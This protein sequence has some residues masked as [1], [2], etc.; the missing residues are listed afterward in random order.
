MAIVVAPVPTVVP[1]T[2]KG[3]E[4]VFARY[5]ILPGVVF[6]G[7]GNVIVC[8]AVVCERLNVVCMSTVPEAAVDPPT[9]IDPE[10]PAPL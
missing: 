8:P 7:V 9:L 10:F 4:P 2:S 5:T 6:D 1:N 3:V